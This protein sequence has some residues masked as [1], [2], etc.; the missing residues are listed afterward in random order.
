MPPI[1]A[2]CE[3]CGALFLANNL[4]GVQ[5]GGVATVS[6]VNSRV[7]PC[8]SCGGTGLIPDG[9][10]EVTNTLVRRL[11]DVR[12]DDLVR[13]RDILRESQQ[14]PRV[15]PD[16]VVDQIEQA[17]PAVSGLRALLSQGGTPLATWITLLL[18]IV[19]MLLDRC[20]ADDEKEALSEDQVEQIVQ[21]ALERA[22]TTTTTSRRPVNAS[23]T[24]QQS[25]STKVGRNER[26]P[27]GSERKFKFCCGP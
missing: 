13:L 26:C 18:M 25:P 19:T 8:P 22:A 12:V 6:F 14:K 17:V 20:E 24:S 23:S 2:V 1:P 10:Y 9:L 3:R 16:E 5:A 11:S 4:I 21:D 7:G 15:A 27:C